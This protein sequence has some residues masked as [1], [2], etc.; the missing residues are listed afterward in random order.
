MLDIAAYKQAQNQASIVKQEGQLAAAQEDVAI[1]AMEADRKM[2]LADALASQR[3]SAAGRGV[4]AFEGSPITV[5][6]E[7]ARRSEIEGERNRFSSKIA[8]QAALYKSR[9][10]A[11][12]IKSRAKL[13][14]AKGLQSRAA[15]MSTGSNNKAPVEDKSRVLK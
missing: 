1:T 13:Q 15:G 3:A 9:S 4:S 7:T 5:I 6:D 8:K 12:G 14:L 2:A 11:S 10:Q